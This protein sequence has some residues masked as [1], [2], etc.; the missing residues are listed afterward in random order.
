MVAMPAPMGGLKSRDLIGAVFSKQLQSTPV[1]RYYTVFYVSR[2]EA[3]W[4]QEKV[5]LSH[6]GDWKLEGYWIV[7][8]DDKGQPKKSQ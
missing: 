2:F 3:G 8:S 7:P 1:G 5:I 6:N 4:Y